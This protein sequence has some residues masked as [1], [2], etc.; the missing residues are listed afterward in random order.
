[1]LRIS[2]EIWDI[3]GIN[4]IKEIKEYPSWNIRDS[5]AFRNINEIDTRKG[6]HDIKG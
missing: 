1:M 2:K 4:G 6:F 5:K 3:K